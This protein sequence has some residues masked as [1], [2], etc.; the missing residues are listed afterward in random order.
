M[1]GFKSIYNL[2]MLKFAGLIL[3]I[4]ASFSASMAFAG[5]DKGHCRQIYD[6]DADIEVASNN[7]IS[8]KYINAIKS[9]SMDSLDPFQLLFVKNHK[10]ALDRKLGNGFDINSCGGLFNSSLLGLA[11]LMG[12]MDDIKTILEYGADLEFPRDSAGQSPLMLAISANRYDVANYLIK[13]G[14]KLKSAYGNEYEYS[15]LNVLARSMKDKS[16]NEMKEL[17][18]ARKLMS[19]GLSANTIDKNPN[20]WMTPLMSAI[21]SDK[22]GLVKLFLECG[23]DPYIKDKRGNDSFHFARTIDSFDAA[24][25]MQK[26][27]KMLDILQKPRPA[28]NSCKVTSNNS[29][30]FGA[31]LRIWPKLVVF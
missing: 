1:I 11:A 9:R 29:E 18:L 30:R 2:I 13:R 4:A 21:I 31:A 16:R 17:D 19:S 3:I 8:S 26:R 10:E 27:E 24:K 7:E 25:N 6:T 5:N 20:V 28:S 22:P 15:A 14:A 12:Q 23:A